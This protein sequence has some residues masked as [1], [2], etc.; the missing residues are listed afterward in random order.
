[1]LDQVRVNGNLISWA[2]T[3]LKING[4]ILNGLVSISWDEKRER[5]FGYG[6][7]RSHGP[8]GRTAG[9]YTPGNVKI[10]ANKDSVI[11]MRDYLGAL[12]DDGRSFGNTRFPIILQYVEPGQLPSTVVFE[13][14]AVVSL[15]ASDEESPDPRYEEWEFSTMR[16]RTDDLTLYDSSVEG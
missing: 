1:M 9:K 12:A 13:D 3:Q 5:A 14:C 16:I 6:M 10:K 7:S 11:A 15:T 2:S 8:R 4:E